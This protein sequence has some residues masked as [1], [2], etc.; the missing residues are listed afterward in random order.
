MVPFT[1]K[2]GD[3]L[4]SGY[5]PPELEMDA[6]EQEMMIVAVKRPLSNFFSHNRIDSLSPKADDWIYRGENDGKERWSSRHL[7]ESNLGPLC[8][9]PTCD[10][11]T[12]L[13]PLSGVGVMT[14][15]L[16]AGFIHYWAGRP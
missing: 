9:S 14:P 13:C 10:P 7:G 2:K 15:H 4:T 3:S 5:H 8:K 6:S 11:L 1:E 16:S 12:L